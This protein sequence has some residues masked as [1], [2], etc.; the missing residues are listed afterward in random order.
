MSVRTEGGEELSKRRDVTF[1]NCKHV[2]KGKD[3]SLEH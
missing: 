3:I 2:N 1:Y